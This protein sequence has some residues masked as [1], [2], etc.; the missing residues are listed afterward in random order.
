MTCNACGTYRSADDNFCRR[1][2]SVLQ[3]TAP[4]LRLPV[5]RPAPQLPAVWQ[6]A[7]PVVARGAALVA[8]GIATEWLMR[9]AARKA[10]S[11]P[12]SGDRRKARKD[13]AIIPQTNGQ[14]RED[15]LAVTETIFI[16]RLFLRR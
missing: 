12:A 1:C 7:A 13:Q 6:Q 4:N 3:P 5:K 2:G 8:A 9:L 15:A 11:I 14:I 10:F 16:R